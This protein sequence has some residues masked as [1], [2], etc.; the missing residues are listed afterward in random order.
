MNFF[1]YFIKDKGGKKTKEFLKRMKLLIPF[2]D[3]EKL[4]IKEGIYKPNKGKTGRPSIP[5]RILIGS[6]FL[7]SWYGLS[8]PQTEEQINDRISFRLFLDIKSEDTIPDET[9][10]CKFR[11]KLIEKGLMKRIFEETKMRMI[12]KGLIMKEGT[13]V[14]ATLIHSS[15]PKKKKDKDGNVISNKANDPDATYARKRGKKY[16]GY[17]MHIAA[18]RNSMIKKVIGTPANEADITQLEE[19]IEG[20]TKEVYGDSAYMSGKYRERFEEEKIDSNIIYRRVKGQKELSKAQSE[21]N[22]KVAKVRGLVELPFAFIKHIMGFKVSKYIG[23]K[24]N[25][26]HFYLLAMSYNFKR[27]NSIG[28]N[29][30]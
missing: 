20:E 19:L 17:K 12:E 21:H 16:H 29:S 24:K 11:N 2:K 15:E 22:K 30:V 4:L 27:L 10:I 8:D 1:D 13:L 9:T 28:V 25:Q 3:I 23:L 26:E 6:L 7:Q 14:D 18:D 5:A